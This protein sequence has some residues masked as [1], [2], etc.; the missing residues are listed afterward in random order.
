MAVDLSKSVQHLV[1][2]VFGIK[3]HGIDPS[4]NVGAGDVTIGDDLTTVDLIV[5]GATTL[6]GS[7]AIGNATTDL[8]GFH[9]ATAVDQ[10]A[11]YTQTYATAGRTVSNVTYAAPAV[12]AA[13]HTYPA[14]GNLFDAT[15]ADLLI[16]VRTDTVGNAVADVVINEK[17]LAANLNQSIVDT[18]AT[19]T[20]VAALAAD[21]LELRKLVTSLIDDL[22]EVGLVG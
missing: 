15:A 21:A 6:N 20:A 2:E 17:S 16:N 22:Q 3:D 7:V 8:V 19:N 9:G 4:L 13:A 11:A 1:E 18:A 14:S 10:A 5:S 12:T